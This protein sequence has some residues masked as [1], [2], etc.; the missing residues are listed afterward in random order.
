MGLLAIFS[1]A[2]LY[3]YKCTDSTQVGRKVKLACGSE[4][5][6]RIWSRTIRFQFPRT[7]LTRKRTVY[8]RESFLPTAFIDMDAITAGRC[9][10]LSRLPNWSGSRCYMSGYMPHILLLLL[11]NFRVRSMQWIFSCAFSHSSFRRSI[12]IYALC[13]Y[14]YYVRYFLGAFCIYVII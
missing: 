9:V 11:K 13:S 5:C 8:W 12:P 6:L 14:C 3:F 4:T 2:R 10:L 7:K 1:F